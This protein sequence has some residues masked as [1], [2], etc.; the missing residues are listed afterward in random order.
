MGTA[1]PFG[2]CTCARLVAGS[3][4]TAR[5]VSREWASRI[6]DL[7]LR[8]V[9][10]PA[11]RAAGAVTSGLPSPRAK[12]AEETSGIPHGAQNVRRVKVCRVMNVRSGSLGLLLVVATA[13]C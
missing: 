4:V 12:D 13:A 2:S 7:L 5:A 8:R 9:Y 6:G 3:R 10:P 11:A 1:S